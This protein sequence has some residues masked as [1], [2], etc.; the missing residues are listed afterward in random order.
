MTTATRRL[1]RVSIAGLATIATASIAIAGTAG[2]ASANI[3]GGVLALSGSAGTV[4]PGTASQALPNVTV[5]I[6]DASG[7]GWANGDFITFQLSSAPGSL[8]ALCNTGANLNQTASLAK[9]AVAGLDGGSTAFTGF[10]VTQ[11]AS[12]TCSGN[13]TFQI[14]FT[15]GAPADTNSTVFTVS[16]LAASLGTAVPTGPLALY[17]TVNTTSAQLAPRGVTLAT[18][19]SASLSTSSTGVAAGATAVSIAPIVLTDVVGGKFGTSITFTSA[20]TDSFTTVG[21]LTAPSGVTVTNTP[22]AGHAITFTLSAAGPAGGVYT[23]TGA[24]LTVNT[25]VGA[26]LVTVTTA[27]T[28]AGP[29]LTAQYAFVGATTREGG[30]DRYGTAALLFNNEFGAGVVAPQTPATIAVIASGVNYPDALS[31]NYLAGINSTGVL[32]TDPNVLPSPTQQILSNGKIT[33]VYIVGGTAA[34]SQNVQNS[35]AALK[36][37][38]SGLNLTVIRIAGSDRYQTNEQV[39]LSTGVTS[40]TATTAIVVTG[41]NFA[42]ALSV[43]PIV[44]N[45]HYPLVL[46][47]SAAL[48]TAASATLTA[49]GITHADI[50]GGTSA[51]STS[52]ETAITALGVTIDNR[53]AGADRTQTAAQVAD[54]AA[55]ATGTT[56]AESGY[57]GAHGLG[58]TTATA[59]VSRGDTYPD[60]LAAGASL[61]GIKAAGP[62]AAPQVLLLTADANTLGAGIGSYLSAIPGGA[63]VTTVNAIGLASAISGKTLAAALGS[64]S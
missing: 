23:L 32:L 15:A 60:A 35:I 8:V 14:A 37:P 6:P 34:V 1:R 42:D 64:A 39:D 12:G 27:G 17:T 46:T 44:A 41:E 11:A 50:A 25:P 59:N 24:Q 10:T 55:T 38:T 40:T 29:P 62:I 16:G 45:N 48:G 63:H 36:N 13:D 7:A 20:G 47:P 21:T 61:G 22:A 53:L 5:T 26:H 19:G 51:V 2:V 31:A 43:G 56:F 33:T 9:P 28:Y 18:I 57:S 30:A 3:T 49:L 4:F 54:W 58:F 52:V